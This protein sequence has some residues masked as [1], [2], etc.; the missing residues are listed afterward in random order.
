LL[1]CRLD[2]SLYVA[3]IDLTDQSTTILDIKTFFINLPGKYF[4]APFDLQ[5]NKY[6]SGAQFEAIYAA[7]NKFENLLTVQS[8]DFTIINSV[9]AFEVDFT[10]TQML[11]ETKHVKYK[12]GEKY[13]TGAGNPGN[14][15]YYLI[16][17][18]DARVLF[19]EKFSPGKFGWAHA[20]IDY[21]RFLD[22]KTLIYWG[23]GSSSYKARILQLWNFASEGYTEIKLLNTDEILKDD[24]VYYDNIHSCALHKKARL[25]ALAFAAHEC[26]QYSIK[27]LKLD[28]ENDFEIIFNYIYEDEQSLVNIAFNPLGDEFSILE[29]THSERYY[30]PLNISIRTYSF[31]SHVP[32]NVVSTKINPSADYVTEI[33]YYS[34][35]VLCIITSNKIFLYNIL[36]G[37]EI[38]ILKK[39]EGLTYH[40]SDRKL[41]YLV[42]EKLTIFTI[43]E[44]EFPQYNERD[45]ERFNFED[46]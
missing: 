43:E 23:D 45:Y 13:R 5:N 18:L 14:D 36:T 3:I 2:R 12:I 19:H 42:N 30:S 27:I 17:D 39:D 26:P 15:F 44:G 41:F 11:L 1:K 16:L 31:K 8:P 34:S 37:D 38:A 40:I 28:S 4:K 10:N 32:K 22:P 20:E 21:L 24:E 25:I 29:Y 6:K 46:K 35:E 7:Y 33:V 9:Q